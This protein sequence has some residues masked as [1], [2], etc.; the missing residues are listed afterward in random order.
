MDGKCTV[1]KKDR[2]DW[3]DFAKGIGIILVIIGHSMTRLG[4]EGIQHIFIVLI[5]SFYMPFFFFISGINFKSDMSWSVFLKKKWKGIMYPTIIFSIILFGG[6]FGIC[7]LDNRMNDFGEMVRLQG[8]DTLLMNRK[9]IVS[10]YW[11]L[12]ALFV[13]EI[14]C[15]TYLKYCLKIK[16]LFIISIVIFIMIKVC[17]AYFTLCLPFSLELGLILL[18]F[19]V[20]GI[21]IARRGQLERLTV[22]Y[23]RLFLVGIVFL[24]GNIFERVIGADNVSIGALKTGSF[25][26]FWINAYSGI[27]A[28]IILAK[29]VK[30][31]RVVNY[32]GK[33]SLSIYGMHYL[34]LEVFYFVCRDFVKE[35]N[36]NVLVS[37][38]I[39][40]GFVGCYVGCKIIDYVK[41]KRHLIMRFHCINE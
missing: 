27:L 4:G 12:P 7:C 30:N 34:F 22:S 25:F 6:K 16:P 10:E 40:F 21:W 39:V 37:I 1:T 41:S 14:V 18:N 20:S 8:I 33:N 26:M 31:I 2:V 19:I 15:F 32:F 38:S 28:V 24:G 29:M 35:I 13:S 11:F 3:I 23:K 17:N 9:S 5:S 36:T